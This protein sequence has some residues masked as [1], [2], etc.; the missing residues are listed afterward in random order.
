M[1]L[2]QQLRTQW[3]EHVQ[4]WIQQDQSIRTGMLDAWMLEALG[5]VTGRRL[6]DIGCGEG[7]FC[8]VLAGL[9]A[10]VTGIDLTEPL[11]E[12][13]AALASGSETYLVGNAEDLVGVEDESFDLA[14]SYIV[15]V[16]I[17]DWRRSIQAAYRV[18]RP[19]GRFIVCNIH[20]MRMAQPNG[21]V[22]Q[23][24]RK[25]F[26]AVDGYSDEGPRAFEWWGETF[27]NMHRTLSSYISAFLEAGFVLEG[28]QE[29]IPSDAQLAANPSFADEFRVPNF[30]IYALRKPAV[31]EA[32][33][34]SR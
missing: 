9:G 24:D 19:G 11:I 21:W 4:D 28:L 17:L 7:R 27:I 14:V 29:P 20:P 32:C 2:K 3:T 16:D 30:I 10:R 34:T 18:L 31:K 6:L 22:K 13:A 26:Y 8:R 33:Q 1:D 25:L 5:D 12:Q 15:L 23:G